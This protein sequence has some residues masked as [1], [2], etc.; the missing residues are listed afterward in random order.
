MYLRLYEVEKPSHV[1]YVLYYHV[2][3]VTAFRNKSVIDQ[4]MAEFLREFFAF[5][6][7]EM[8][9]QLLEQKIL[10][11][12]AHLLLSLRPSHYLPEVVNY[13]KGTASHEANHHHDFASSLD[14]LRGYHVDPVSEDYLEE[15]RS[16]IKNQ[17]AFHPKQIPQK[18]SQEKP[19]HENKIPYWKLNEQHRANDTTYALYYHVVWSTTKRLPLIDQPMAQFLWEFFLTK[20]EKLDVRLL[21]QNILSDH[22]HLFLNQQPTHYI[23]QVINGLKGGSSYE[24][25]KSGDFDATLSWPRGYRVQTVSKRDLDSVKLYIQNQY[26]HHPDKIPTAPP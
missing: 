13:L 17:Y 19:L 10:S 21:E 20:S 7:K 24:T 9:V 18:P 16:H 15:A 1:S 6:C 26:E 25:N 2:V 4:P 22:V 14:W 3:L 23:P 5:K 12:H 8:E 11:F